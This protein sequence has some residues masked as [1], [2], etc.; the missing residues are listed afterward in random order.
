MLHDS[1]TAYE[2][3]LL[4]IYNFK[5][6]IMRMEWIVQFQTKSN[7]P[8]YLNNQTESKFLHLYTNLK[9][10]KKMIIGIRYKKQKVINQL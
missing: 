5:I 6:N 9:V 2:I 10:K 4:Y 7:Y 8:T 3:I 1:G